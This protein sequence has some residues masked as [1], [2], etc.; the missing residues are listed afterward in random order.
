MNK[1]LVNEKVRK[2]KWISF[3]DLVI[4]ERFI[5]GSDIDGTAPKVGICKKV[6][7]RE[8]KYGVTVKGICVLYTEVYTGWVSKN[9][10]VVRINDRGEPIRIS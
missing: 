2:Y 9:F 10:V 7:S 6:S 5:F 8:Y 1:N 4:G 3:K